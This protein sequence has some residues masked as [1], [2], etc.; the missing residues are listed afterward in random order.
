MS[1]SC[2]GVLDQRGVISMNVSF[3][4]DL[5]RPFGLVTLYFGY[6]EFEVDALLDALVGVGLTV[7]IP[8]ISSLGQKLAW[9]V[10]FC[11]GENLLKPVN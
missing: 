7:A 11:L 1:T 9:C 10:R 6:A 3:E 4:G 8:R 5:I 2:E